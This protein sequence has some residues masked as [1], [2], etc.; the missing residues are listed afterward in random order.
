[1]PLYA[2]I[3]VVDDITKKAVSALINE[4]ADA[5][6]KK[7]SDG[8]NVH[9]YLKDSKIYEHVQLNADFENLSWV[10]KVLY[11]AKAFLRGTLSW[12]GKETFTKLPERI[13]L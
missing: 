13:L 12:F 4:N 3:S 2:K 6:T 7:I 1:M 9:D 11:K 8:L 5:G 10:Y